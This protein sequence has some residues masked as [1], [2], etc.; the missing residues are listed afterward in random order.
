VNTKVAKVVLVSAEGVAK[1]AYLT[2]L[3]S[4][5]LQVDPVSS[6]TELYALLSK[7]PY[8]GIIVDIRT[9]VKASRE[10]KELTNELLDTFPVLQLKLDKKTGLVRNYFYGQT[11]DS[12]TLE[13]F[14]NQEC[15]SFKARKIRL[16]KRQKIHFNIILSKTGSFE[17]KDVILTVTINVSKRGCFIYS[18]DDFDIN[19]KVFFIIKEIGEEKENIA[20]VIWKMTWG[21][22]M[23]IPGIGVKF[24]NIELSEN[25]QRYWSQPYG[26]WDNP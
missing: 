17:K 2:A 6:F 22:T 1:Q 8:N 12:G 19:S 21:E 14:I 24:E 7:K 15:R 23:Q 26:K 9:K 13:T 16:S 10:E 3:N 5:D 4:F 11:R 25:L 18:A 20:E